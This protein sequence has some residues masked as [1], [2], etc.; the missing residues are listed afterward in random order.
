MTSKKKKFTLATWVDVTIEDLVDQLNDKEAIATIKA[1]DK[2][3]ED[4][5]FTEQLAVYFVR[6]M[7][8]EPDFNMEYFLNKVKNKKY[9]V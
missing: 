2:S 4:Y 6:E 8:G 9:K 3:R 5:G 1:L 7:L